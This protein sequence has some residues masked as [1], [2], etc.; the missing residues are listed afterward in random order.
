MVLERNLCLDDGYGACLLAHLEDQGGLHLLLYL[1][2]GS[3]AFTTTSV[4]TSSEGVSFPNMNPSIV[5]VHF[6][7][8]EFLR[9]TL[10]TLFLGMGKL[11][12]KDPGFM[13]SD[14]LLGIRVVRLCTIPVT[15]RNWTGFTVNEENLSHWNVY[16]KLETV[17]V[18]AW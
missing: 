15:T 2:E 11:S 1:Q 14:C 9:E 16:R 3:L 18:T 12:S 6:I 10:P 17:L 5:W 13:T 8:I 4:T 7:K